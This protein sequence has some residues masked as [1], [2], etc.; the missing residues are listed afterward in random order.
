MATFLHPLQTK[1]LFGLRSVFIKLICYICIFG[2]SLHSL[3]FL[4]LLHYQPR[5]KCHLSPKPT[6]EEK[7]LSKRLGA[8]DPDISYMIAEIYVR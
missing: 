5:K 6:S 7:Q 4:P 8:E 2:V 3:I 1:H